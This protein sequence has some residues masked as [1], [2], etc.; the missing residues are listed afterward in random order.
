MKLVMDLV[1]NHTT[2]E[3][4]WFAE[5]RSSKDNPK[6][7]WYWWRPRASGHQPGTPGAEPTNWG[8]AFS[9]PAWTYDPATGEYYLH[10]FAPGQ[11][12][13]NWENPEV[14]QAV[15]AMMSWWLDRGVDG[16]RMDVINL[17]S[18]VL[19]DGGCPTA[20]GARPDRRRRHRHHGT[21][22]RRRWSSTAR[23]STSSCRRCTA[24]CSPD[25]ARAAQRR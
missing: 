9:G 20:A 16:F 12:D 5:S 24:R 22:T 13:L 10:L 7:D 25:A 17:I 23:A 19:V 11:P 14:R 15:Y 1:V 6:R 21:A 2:D 3:H 8:S 4:A 18:K